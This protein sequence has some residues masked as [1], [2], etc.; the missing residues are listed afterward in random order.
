MPFPVGP[1]GP[2]DSLPRRGLSLEWVEAWLDS[3]SGGQYVLLL[4]GAGDGPLVLT[5]PQRNGD[6]VA[7][8]RTYAEATAWLNEDEYDLAEGRWSAKA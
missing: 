2:S 6:T 7:E 1:N 8:F 5:D 3:A 4:R